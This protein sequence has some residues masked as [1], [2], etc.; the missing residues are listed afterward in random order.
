MIAHHHLSYSITSC[1]AAVTTNYCLSCYC[2]VHHRGRDYGASHGDSH[3]R[4]DYCCYSPLVATAIAYSFT[5]HRFGYCPCSDYY[6]HCCCR[7]C[8]CYWV[9][10]CYLQSRSVTH[11]RHA[12]LQGN[13]SWRPACCSSGYCCAFYAWSCR[14]WQM[15]LLSHCYQ[16]HRPFFVTFGRGCHSKRF[17]AVWHLMTLCSPRCLR[18]HHGFAAQYSTTKWMLSPPN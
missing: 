14:P 3:L 10:M 13:C 17:V 12:S 16:F 15:D 5:D 18:N 11:C 9:L 7:L 8:Y 6:C 4:L 2:D 1:F